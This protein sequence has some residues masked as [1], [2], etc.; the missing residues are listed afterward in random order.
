[1]LSGR[2]ATEGT[3]QKRKLT[4]DL[5]KCVR[6]KKKHTKRERAKESAAWSAGACINRLNFAGCPKVCNE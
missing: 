1:M 3:K 2:E 4:T 6:E 5:I